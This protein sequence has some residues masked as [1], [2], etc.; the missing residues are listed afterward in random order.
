MIRTRR[1]HSLVGWA[2]YW[3]Y[4]TR[5]AVEAPSSCKAGVLARL[6]AK[7]DG[8]DELYMQVLL[9]EARLLTYPR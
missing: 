9:E 1:H 8:L 2:F 6:E 7:A 3:L 5:V 4:L